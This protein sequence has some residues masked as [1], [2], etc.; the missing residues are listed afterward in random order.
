MPWKSHLK[1]AC[2]HKAEIA[3]HALNPVDARPPVVDF[4]QKEAGEAVTN[5]EARAHS[6][7]CQEPARHQSVKG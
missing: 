5:P 3:C 4:G 1:Q 6:H 7:D 2:A